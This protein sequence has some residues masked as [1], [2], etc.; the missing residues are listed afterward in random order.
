M[1]VN[2]SVVVPVIVPEQLSVV[3]GAVA[4]AE[5]SPV[6]SASVG[7]SG[8]VTS[9]LQADADVADVVDY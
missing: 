2:G 4:V 3:V 1:Y 9:H 8:S 7:V 6:T 5:H